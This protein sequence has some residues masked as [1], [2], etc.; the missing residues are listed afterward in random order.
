MGGVF[1]ADCW[2]LDQDVQ[3]SRCQTTWDKR[4]V[5][6]GFFQVHFGG[7]SPRGNNFLQGRTDLRQ[8]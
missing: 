8:Y 2:T 5:I 6:L 3:V 1:R 7:G 4:D